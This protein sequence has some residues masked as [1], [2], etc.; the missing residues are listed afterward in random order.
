MVTKNKKMRR[1]K[2]MTNYDDK[3]SQDKNKISS[4]NYGKENISMRIFMTAFM[5]TK[6]PGRKNL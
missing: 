3:K 2:I 6:N 4:T 1:K 5:V